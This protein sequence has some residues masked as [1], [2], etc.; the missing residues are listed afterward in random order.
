MSAVLGPPPHIAFGYR[1]SDPFY[2]SQ[3]GMSYEMSASNLVLSGDA[4]HQDFPASVH[5]CPSQTR[6]FLSYESTRM[7]VFLHGNF[8]SVHMVAPAKGRLGDDAPSGTHER[9]C[10]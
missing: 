10:F 4:E 1:Y 7:P 8:S 6:A 3:E 9:W 2:A 5:L